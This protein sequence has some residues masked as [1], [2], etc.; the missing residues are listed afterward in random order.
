MAPFF[1]MGYFGEQ[2]GFIVALLIGIAFGFWLERAGFGDST[3]LAKQFYFK[4]NTVIK[5]MFTSVLVAMLGVLYFTLFGWFDINLLYINPTFLW[6]QVVGGIIFGFGFV[7]GG[8]CPGTSVVGMVTGRIDGIVFI[9]GAMFG[10]FVFGEMFPG[11]ESLFMA[12][13]MGSITVPA[14]LNLS[15]GIVALLVVFLALGMFFGIDWAHK[16]LAKEEVQ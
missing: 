15:S 8:Y 3:V 13:N 10:M 7:I 14:F 9:L 5:V 16:K 2:T 11:I 12:G 6:A 1:K 4:N